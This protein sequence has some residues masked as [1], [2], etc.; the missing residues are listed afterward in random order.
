MKYLPWIFILMTLSVSAQENAGPR[1]TALASAGVAVQDVWS[2]KQNQAG[3]A[4]L[5][6]VVLALGYQQ[7][8]AGQELSVQSAL[9]AMPYQKGTWGLSFQRYGFSVYSEQQSG[10]SY[11][12]KFGDKLFAALTFNYHQLKISGYGSAQTFSVSAGM[13]YQPVENLWMGAHIANPGRSGYKQKVEALIPVKIEF[14]TAYRFSDKVLVAGSWTK[15]L[16]SNTDA[17]TGLE[18]K[19]II[20]LDLRGG[21]S[22]NPFK[23]YAGFGL[24]AQKFRFDAAAS[25]H[26]YLGYSPQI[27]FSYEF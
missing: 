19:P 3:S 18:Y 6:K 5:Q 12:R 23:Q 9:L 7:P 25:F 15:E 20:W 13:Q 14:G 2:L 22:V 27:A 16:N 11:A 1:L 8:F 24:N 21:I 26:P 17:K 10:L 4:A